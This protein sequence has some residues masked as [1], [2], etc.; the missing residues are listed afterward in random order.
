MAESG[1]SRA[2]AGCFLTDQMPPDGWPQK[3]KDAFEAEVKRIMDEN[4]AKGVSAEGLEDKKLNVQKIYLNELKTP[5]FDVSVTNGKLSKGAKLHAMLAA[6]ARAQDA[7]AHKALALSSEQWL[8]ARV[9]AAR[10]GAC[11]RCA[12]GSLR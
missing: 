1:A 6:V 10:V 5:G 4:V 11:L 3:D 7:G 8:Q 2:A 9:K 12:A